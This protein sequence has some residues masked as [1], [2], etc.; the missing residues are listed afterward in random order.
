MVMFVLAKSSKISKFLN[1]VL[2]PESYDIFLAIRAD[3]MGFTPPEDKMSE[4]VCRCLAHGQ[5][6]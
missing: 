4:M 1:G 2:A 6:G 3:P 5:L